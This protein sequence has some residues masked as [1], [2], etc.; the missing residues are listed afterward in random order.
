MM[1]LN[2]EKLLKHS[3][4]Q[5]FFMLTQLSMRYNLLIDIKKKPESK[6]FYRLKSSKLVNYP[7]VDILTFMTMIDFIPS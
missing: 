3:R 4:Y 2:C 7:A 1:V 6:K 5:N